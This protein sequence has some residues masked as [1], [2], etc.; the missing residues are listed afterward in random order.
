[1]LLRLGPP[2]CLVGEI[3]GV[4]SSGFVVF[5]TCC[6]CFFDVC[7]CF[8]GGGGGFG[9]VFSLWWGG[10]IGQLG[11]FMRVYFFQNGICVWVCV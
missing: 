2:Y 7:L 1:M 8:L 6:W 3:S 5:F 4:F 10:L 9:V 11:G